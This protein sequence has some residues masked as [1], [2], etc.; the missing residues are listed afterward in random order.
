MTEEKIIMIANDYLTGAYSMAELGYKYGVSK[1]TIVRALS[2]SQNV[3]LPASLQKQVD[4]KK[5]EAWYVSKSTKGNLGHTKFTDEE[6]QEKAVNLVEG[7]KTLKQLGEERQESP[8]TLY[9]NFTEERLGTELYE[10][11]QTVY[12]E[13]KESGRF[14]GNKSNEELASMLVEGMANGSGKSDEG[15]LKK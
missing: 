10:Q 8:S 4:D 14:N 6:V 12:K 5:R 13:N 15:H 2:G 9:V 1:A 3:K 7:H 11:V